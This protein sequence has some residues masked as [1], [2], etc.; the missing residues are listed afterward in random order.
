VRS[1]IYNIDP[2]PRKGQWAAIT[3]KMASYFPHASPLVI[4]IVST[5]DFEGGGTLLEFAPPEGTDLDPLIVFDPP[6]THPSHEQFLRYFDTRGIK[7]LLQVEPGHAPVGKL[8]DLV[9]RRFGHH[10]SVIGIGVDAEWYDNSTDGDPGR[11]I[12]DEDAQAWEAQV[13]SYNPRYRLFLKHWESK[14]LP[15]TYRGQIIFVDDGQDLDDLQDFLE[16]TK[17]FS[18]AFYPN[19]VLFQV[20]YPSDRTWW[21]TLKRP[22]PR[23]I[24]RALAAQTR[25]PCGIIWTD[26]TLRQVF[27]F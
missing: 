8:I 25:Q 13:K 16:E 17:Y 5:V 24:G 18:N 12:S 11:P 7:V 4:W 14:Q 9:L 27:R 19:L 23:T 1:S 26:K 2:F 15:P 21:R 10:R 22:I 6:T 20:G 3:R